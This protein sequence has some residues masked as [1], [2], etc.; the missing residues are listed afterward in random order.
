MG[1]GWVRFG[2]DSAHFRASWRPDSSESD[3]TLWESFDESSRGATGAE[4]RAFRFFFF[5][6]FSKVQCRAFS[7]PFSES[8]RNSV[9]NDGIE[10]LRLNSGAS[11]RRVRVFSLSKEEKQC[12]LTFE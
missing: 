10:S 1:G 2:L 8:T 4:L 3:P 11:V 9:A 6:I 5:S 12:F 7:W